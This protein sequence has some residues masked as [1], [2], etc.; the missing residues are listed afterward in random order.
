MPISRVG[1]PRDSWVSSVQRGIVLESALCLLCRYRHNTHWTDTHQ[2]SSFLS[3]ES[4]KTVGFLRVI[5][6]KNEIEEVRF[7]LGELLLLLCFAEIGIHADIVLAFVF[8]EIE[9]FEAR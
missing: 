5:C 4:R 2:P 9:N 7:F 1:L 3:V 6:A 8:A